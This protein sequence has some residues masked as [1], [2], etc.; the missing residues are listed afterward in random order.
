MKLT[1][2]MIEVAQGNFARGEKLLA[3]AEEDFD[4]ERFGVLEETIQRYD[5]YSAE[6]RAAAACAR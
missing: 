2:G 1:R 6:S 4:M 3:R 5:G